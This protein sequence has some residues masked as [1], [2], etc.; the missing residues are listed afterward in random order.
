MLLAVALPLTVDVSAY[1]MV[2]IALLGVTVGM[3]LG[4]Y[5]GFRLINMG[6]K[7]LETLDTFPDRLRRQREDMLDEQAKVSKQIDR[8]VKAGGSG[9]GGESYKR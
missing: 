9:F 8:E 3:C 1:A 5:I 2:A 6:M 4:A 7:W